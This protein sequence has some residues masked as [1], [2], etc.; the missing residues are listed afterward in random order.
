MDQR[1]C[2][3]SFHLEGEVEE[4]VTIFVGNLQL[5]LI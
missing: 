4:I 2:L 1:M 5:N 3:E